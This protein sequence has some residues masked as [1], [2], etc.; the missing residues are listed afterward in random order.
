MQRRQAGSGGVRTTAASSG[1]LEWMLCL[2][3]LIPGA[4]KRR[5]SFKSAESRLMC[6]GPVNGA[7]RRV[8]FGEDL[9]HFRNVTLTT[10]VHAAW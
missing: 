10:R 6:L 1:E 2:H 7:G 3:K 9:Q 4:S 8:G 5:G